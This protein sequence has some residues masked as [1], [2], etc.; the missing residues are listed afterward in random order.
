[1][2]V[3]KDLCPEKMCE[4]NRIFFLYSV[5]LQHEAEDGHVGPQRQWEK[6]LWGVRQT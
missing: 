4:R 3:Q 5:P 1:M 2:C 6:L